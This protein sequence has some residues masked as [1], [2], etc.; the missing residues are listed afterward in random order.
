MS[1][2]RAAGRLLAAL[3]ALLISSASYAQENIDPTLKAL[4]LK[5]TG[6]GGFRPAGLM[7]DTPAPRVNLMVRLV[8]GGDAQGLRA[9]FPDAVFYGPVGGILT[10]E[11]P[12]SDIARLAADPAVSAAEGAR[13]L[14]LTLDVVRS[15]INSGGIWYGA[16]DGSSVDF[17]TNLGSGVVVGFVDSGID[18][19][20]ADF[21]TEGSPNKTRI[22]SIWDQTDAGGPNPS[23]FAYGSEW[24]RT[25]IDNEID[26]S[27]AG[28]V[29]QT[30]TVGHGTHV[31]GIAVGDGTAGAS[32]LAGLAPKADI[33]MVKSNLQNSK[34]IDGMSYIVAK[35]A[36]AG[37][38]AVINLSLGGHYGPHDGTSTFETGVAAIAASTPVVVAMGNEED[39]E[40]HATSVVALSGTSVFTVASDAGVTSLEVD[41]WV[42]SGD[43]YSAVISTSPTG[44]QTAACLPGLDCTGMTIA[45]HTIDVY[46]SPSG[47]PS[48]DR[49][50]TVDVAKG[51]GFTALTWRISLTR[52]ANSGTGRVDG[53]ITTSYSSFTTLVDYSGTVA[54]PA[55]ANNVIAVGSYCSR[56]TWKAFDSSNWTDTDCILAGKL[57]N[58]SYFSNRGPTRDGRQ[59]PDVAAPGQR[60]ASSLSADQSPA[61]AANVKTPDGKHKFSNGTSMAAP[62]I[63][64]AVART[65]EKQTGITAAQIRSNIQ[66]TARSDAKVTSWG[67]VPNPV[68]G[69]GKARILG[70]GNEFSVG[71]ATASPAVLGT[72]SISWTWANL[73][74]ATSYNVYYATSPATLIT[75]VASPALVQTSL[76]ANTTMTIRV[77]GVNDCGEGPGQDSYSTSTLASP[78]ASFASSAHISSITA[79]WTSVP[80]GSGYLL[81]ASTAPNHSGTVFSSATSVS[82]S[83]GLSLTGLVAFTTY[84]VRA[85]TLNR[86]SG[87]HFSPTQQV[88]TN[89]QL[90]QPG[91]GPYTVLGISS[92]T[93]S[94]TLNGNS[95]GLE[96][97]AQ[98]ST[99]SNFSGTLLSSQTW[100]LSATFTGLSINSTYYFQVRPT[101]GP[102]GSLGSTATL[103]GIPGDAGVPFTAVY[104]TSVAVAWTAGSN[105]AGTRYR[106]EL[107][108]TP[109]FLISP[110]S[111][112]TYNTS[113]VFTG[114]NAH[115]V[116]YLR[117]AALNRNSIPTPYT[118]TL[119]SSTLTNAPG[120]AVPVFNFVGPSSASLNWTALPLVPQANTCTRYVLEASTASNFTGR[121]LAAYSANNNSSSLVVTSLVQDSTYYFRVGALNSLGAPVYTALG[122]T[123]TIGALISSS[124][125][126]SGETLVVS[127][128]PSVPELSAVRVEAP[129]GSFP[130]G[131]QLSINATLL[132]GLPAPDTNQGRVAPL[133]G[134][135][136]VDISAEGLQPQRPVTVRFTYVPG[137][138]GGVDPRRLVVG[139]YTAS[140]WTLLPTTLDP[141]ANTITAL[142]THF[143]VFAPLVVTAGTTL[144]SV[145]MFPI[146]WKPGSNDSEFDAQGISLTNLPDGAE[147]RIFT[148]LGEEVERL[149]AGPS[150][151]VL[152]DG[153]NSHGRRVG[154]GTYLV[155]VS[156][157]G[158][159]RVL[160]AAV[161]R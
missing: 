56:N 131:T 16:L 31:A 59:K 54:A 122:S 27:P 70:C 35:A 45:G 97:I 38:R 65:L 64:G 80:S 138:L 42:P 140:G 43:I 123:K 25:Q 73:A 46:N 20:H 52:Q 1:S 4:L 94:W 9:R 158:A 66:A 129:P 36:A 88:F 155:V 21:Y 81:Q 93:A 26:G 23:G 146:P 154:S 63:A 107:A 22:L 62:V 120:T 49:Q 139:R 12:L 68:F 136:G 53:Y 141:S 69:Y 103:A 106:A 33:I 157:A 113:A 32:G 114:L 29:R 124:T 117:V 5:G 85:G 137:A 82:S 132:G 151:M 115:T 133:G 11:V 77:T 153:K 130:E 92:I 108:A 152:W 14:Q 10:G 102:F 134:A 142:T 67:A 95:P 34:V 87:P 84:Y 105:P 156:G 79:T 44:T 7:A 112:S 127:V 75:S 126:V 30:D 57:G 111:S 119:S 48:G 37:K 89:T 78:L 143:S 150:G 17:G 110:V 159:R 99:A 6:S 118:G 145:Q 149:S 100:N 116:Y 8:P 71:P 74:G 24:T 101:T 2:P 121:M 98:A 50:I 39:D 83:G 55:T 13:Q 161:V 72:S 144:D 128:T 86:S 58:I 104:Q 28:I 60:I 148:I 147:V 51:G 135:A 125:V 15:S 40:V 41:F 76:A 90:S 47:H 61:A 91:A 96:Y 3:A 160:R 19:N 109:D 18:Y